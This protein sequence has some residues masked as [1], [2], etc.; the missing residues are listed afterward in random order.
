MINK[1]DL[2][3]VGGFDEVIDTW[4]NED[5][6]LF[7][8]L[9]SLGIRRVDP[10]F[11]QLLKHISHGDERSVRYSRIKDKRKSSLS[12][13]RY[14]DAC[15]NMVCRLGRPLTVDERVELRSRSSQ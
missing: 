8:L 10:K 1:D 6:V 13:Q 7:K 12:T 5:F 4:G 15:I 9:D 11:D 3:S 14:V 2:I